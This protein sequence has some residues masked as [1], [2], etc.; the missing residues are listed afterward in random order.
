MNFKKRRLNK[1]LEER[2]YRVKLVHG[3]KG[4]I[5]V[6]LTFVTLFSLTALGQKTVD[7]SAVNNVATANSTTGSYVQLWNN[8]TKD[9][10]RKA[11]R[12]LQNGTAWKTAKAVKGVDGKT[13]VL[14]GG[15]E[16]ANVNEM[17][18]AD[19]TSS[20]KLS[21]T[22]HV[23]NVE[24]AALYTNPLE[25][26]KQIKNRGLA[27]NSD[28]ITNQK[29]TVDGV[30]Y[31]RVATNEWVKANNA[32]LTSE[33]SRSDKNYIK[34]APDDETV[35]TPD[36]DNNNGSSSS[37]SHNNGGSTETEYANVTVKYVD[38]NG[39][40]IFPTSTIEQKVGETYTSKA[41][42]I[43]GYT[44]NGNNTQ[45]IKVT[46]NGNNT[47]IFAYTKASSEKDATIIL[48]FVDK[49]GKK[50]ADD[51]TD[52]AKVGSTYRAESAQIGHYWVDF[53]GEDGLDR[54]IQV[55]AG[56]NEY[57]FKYKHIGNVNV[58]YVDKATGMRIENIGGGTMLTVGDPFVA[59]AKDIDGYTLIGDKTQT[60]NVA[61]GSTDITFYYNKNDDT[62]T[63][64]DPADK[65]SDVIVDY[66]DENGKTIS[67]KTLA[68]QT[69]GATVSADA[70]TLDGYK[71]NDDASK[72]VTVSKDGNNTITFNY[73][74]DDTTTPVDP[75]DKTA[76]V[77]VNYVDADGNKVAEPKTVS[78][79]KVGSTITEQA[80]TV[81]GYTV[82][83]NSQDVIIAEEGNTI[84]FTYT[85]D[86]TTPVDPV[87]DKSDVTVKYVDETGKEIAQSATTSED[88]G[89]TKSVNAISVDG[90]ELTS[91][92]TQSVN[93]DKDSTKNVITFTYKLKDTTPVT[94]KA[95]VLVHYQDESGQ[96]I[97]PDT[98]TSEEVG[99][100]KTIN[101]TDIAGYTV[102]GNASQD[103]VISKDGN[104]V[105]F[106][107]SKNAEPVTQSTVTTKFV[108][109]DKNE[110]ADAVTEKVDNGKD[111]T[112]TAKTI[113]GYTVDGEATQTV[114]VD[115]DK[116]VT[117][118]YTKD[119]NQNGISTS[120]VKDKL[121]T[122]I[123]NYRVAN[124]QDPLTEDDN[125]TL[126]SDARAADEAN[127]V[128]TSGDIGKAD[129]FNSDKT[130][131]DQESHIKQD[132]SLFKAENLLVTN[133]DSVDTVAQN[134]FNQWKNSPDH[135]KNMLDPE[136]SK[137]GLSVVQL[138]NGQFLAMQD[139]AGSG[140][141]SV[142]DPEM[143][144]TASITDLGYT[145][146]DILQAAKSEPTDP[147]SHSAPI[148]EIAKSATTYF[149]DR[150]FKSLSDYTKWSTT[151][152]N[153]GSIWDEGVGSGAFLAY[154][155]KGNP[156]GF[157]PYVYSLSDTASHLLAQGKTTWTTDYVIPVGEST[158]GTVTYRLIKND[159][160]GYISNAFIPMKTLT[161]KSGDKI[162]ITAPDMSGYR[163]DEAY[164][165]SNTQ[166]IT[167]DVDPIDNDYMF[168]YI[169]NDAP[170]QPEG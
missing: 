17:D 19:E 33:N 165:K 18:L 55:K 35:T 102:K 98:K 21:G 126:G 34:N 48:H 67:S 32:N 22:V 51:V 97:S 158:T 83:K 69:V 105:V 5:T 139:F 31:Y 94:T 155:T 74:A 68:G 77:T 78:S 27:G 167:L 161:G 149:G 112:A 166:E 43:D 116:T 50:L 41:A 47:I 95:D 60:V 141:E 135:N 114:S 84:T 4:W 12:G 87:A 56:V 63:P 30:T 134:A 92:T 53:G 150:V 164:N 146:A 128:N 71:L 127:E 81:D 119:S 151:K 145:S 89:S 38:E 136:Y 143:D 58:Y 13:Y 2:T 154:D 9:S 153:E 44:V 121:L 107:Y 113:D 160:T 109:A 37:G 140:K 24:Y 110:I 65:K 96:T 162:T 152:H 131:F 7:A 137:T 108:D 6:G 79:Q 99:S 39:N 118:T 123:N 29:V 147:T 148:S 86:A 59:T 129:H 76:N 103:V 115:G 15:N 130:M 125:L 26:A 61:E 64:V 88:V 82:D 1:A 80:A 20:Q 90:Y 101:S 91:Q 122:L 49:D 132:N 85:K 45:S 117:F 157:V 73:K 57:T 54:D 120:D 46:K 133:G 28:W 8:V 42:K 100:T 40:K 111:Y 159:R 66:V 168:T 23:G 25:G 70:P 75:A 138:D 169:S 36:T 72:S 10:I 3:K 14:V 16:Y 104:E 142:Y 52:T 62:T 11:N 93:V 106:V 144:N 170:L 163:V 124:S 156:I